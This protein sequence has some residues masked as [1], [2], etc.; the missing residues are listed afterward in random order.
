MRTKVSDML[1]ADAADFLSTVL[2]G[3]WGVRQRDELLR[4]LSGGDVDLE[5]ALL[6]A[7]ALGGWGALGQVLQEARPGWRADASPGVQNAL[8]N[9]GVGS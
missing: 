4:D 3:A 2:D 9:V 7:H 5:K 1:T 6:A 8:E